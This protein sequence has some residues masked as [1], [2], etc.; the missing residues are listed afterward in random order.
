MKPLS[1][2]L[3]LCFFLSASTS[4]QEKQP[5]LIDTD[6]GSD[7][8]DAFALA[9]ALASPEL[10]VIGITTCAAGAEDRAWMVCRFLSHG[11]FKSIPVAFGR[12]PQPDYPIDWQIQYRRHPAVIFNRTHRPLKESAVQLMY[13]KLKEQPGKVTLITLGPLT[14]VARLLKEHPDAKDMIQR[15]VA[16]GGSVDRGYEGKK[17]IEA[18][19]NVKQDAPAARAVFESG[20]PLVLIP[21]DAT[22][23]AKLSKRRLEEIFAPYSRLTMQ[24]QALYQLWGKEEPVMFDPAAVAAAY[25]EKFFSF[26]ELAL[27]VDDKGFTRIGKGKPNARVALDMREDFLKWFVAR[28]AEADKPS[29][30]EPSK[31]LSK[32]IDPGKFPAKVHVCED[33]DTD[34]EKRWWM[35]GRPELKD[36]PPGSR[37]ACRAALTQDFD[38]R[39]GD[40]KTMYQAV[41]FNPVPGPPMGKNTR[42]SFRYKL[43]GTDKMRVQ[44]YSLTNGY[45]RYL[46]LEG[47][48]Q[49]EWK[50]GAVD[51]TD[52]RR[53][54]GTGGP[55]A[56]DERID[57]IQ[58]Y[59]DPKAD[60]IIDDVVLYE[61]ADDKETKP[62]P[63]R[64]IYTAWFDTGKHGKE[65]PGDFE[66]VP[67]EKPRTWK[68]A[69]SV[70][71][72]K[73][74]MWIRLSMKGPRRVG[75]NV[76]LFFKYL[77]KGAETFDVALVDSK[78]GPLVTA[79]FMQAKAD[80][81]SNGTATYRIRGGKGDVT[82]DEIHFLLPRGGEIWIDDAVLYEP[83]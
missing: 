68:A 50:H 32:L 59:L 53:P 55:L 24:V 83:Q 20:V 42:L 66:I 12:D 13:Q 14:N 6:L 65:W 34:I 17:G 75:E 27:E 79:K 36:L 33:F 56:I 11:G 22:A 21:L 74:E 4:A 16:M 76:E 64:F 15:I 73:G 44:L 37:R 45:H 63:G 52:M 2:A 72:D 46:S 38:D 51:M 31:H 25:A 35:T 40:L 70:K 71:N 61:A 67:H 28:V 29:L 30:P 54:D 57:D 39:Q 5:V 26:K 77:L 60:V 19:W 49:N 78:K 43:T 41:V 8:D 80:I 62:F 7:V 48:P 23:E 9:L 58:F 1:L 18:E 10:D 47:L 69:K 81:W 82:V 3:T